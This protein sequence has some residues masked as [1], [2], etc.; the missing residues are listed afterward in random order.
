MGTHAH[1]VQVLHV[2]GATYVARCTSCTFRAYGSARGANEAADR[3]EAYRAAL[4][5]AR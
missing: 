4:D 5:A 2:E 3:H 1:S